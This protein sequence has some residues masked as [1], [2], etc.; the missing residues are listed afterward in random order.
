ML[1]HVCVRSRMF[2]Y[3][4]LRFRTFWY[5]LVRFGT[6]QYVPVCFGIFRYVS[7]QKYLHIDTFIWYIQVCFRSFSSVHVVTM[8]V[9][10]R[11]ESRHIS[12][13]PGGDT[14]RHLATCNCVHV[15]NAF[16]SVCRGTEAWGEQTTRGLTHVGVARRRRCRPWE[17]EKERWGR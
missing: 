6:C 13:L 12:K 9:S 8:R 2:L 17:R 16:F 11:T 5:V 15:A 3:I 1:S 14:P 4:A 10:Y 7:V